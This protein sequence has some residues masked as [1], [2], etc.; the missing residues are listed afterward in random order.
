MTT[1][2]LYNIRNK[3]DAV[4]AVVSVYAKHR[5]LFGPLTQSD[6][7]IVLARHLERV[8]DEL[9]DVK[10]REDNTGEQ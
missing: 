4:S 5:S 1:E 9:Y 2:R 8:I 10:H 6:M 3:L 7:Y